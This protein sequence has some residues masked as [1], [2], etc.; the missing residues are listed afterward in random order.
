MKEYVVT[1][2]FTMDYKS[3]WLIE[4]QKPAWQKGCLNGIGGKIER[5]EAPQQ[6]A[7]R[8]IKEEAGV[9]INIDFIHRVGHMVGVNNDGNKFKVFVFTGK[10]HDKL[11]T[12]E[13]EEIKLMPVNTVKDYRHIE[14][15]PMLIEACLYFLTGNSN[16][17]QLKMIY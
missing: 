12:V 4:K 9:N 8:E 11:K 13:F 5:G 10:T 15:V 6:A 2:L 3:I 1:F 16:F 17:S 7:I 14:N